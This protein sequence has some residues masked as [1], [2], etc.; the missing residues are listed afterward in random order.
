MDFDEQTNYDDLNRDKRFSNYNK[1]VKS[2][3]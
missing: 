3:I 1:R 2:I